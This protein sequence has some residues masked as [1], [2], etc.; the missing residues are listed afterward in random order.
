MSPL[1]YH[2]L[3]EG[4]LSRLGVSA[5]PNEDDVYTLEVDGRLQVLIGCY[6]EQWLQLYCE[7]GPDIAQSDNL[8]G[9]QWPAHVQGTL[10]GQAIL[11]SQQCLSNLDQSSLESWLERFI[12]DAELRMQSS[13]AKVAIPPELPGAGSGLLQRA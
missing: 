1:T 3:V 5:S 11:W 8:F 9:A 6:Q 13:N 2:E 4:L 12:D 7:L 10:D